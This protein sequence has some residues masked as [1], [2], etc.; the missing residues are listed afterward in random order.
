[1]QTNDIVKVSDLKGAHTVFVYDGA[2]N[3][4]FQDGKIVVTGE[5]ATKGD[6]ADTR[7][8]FKTSVPVAISNS[9]K[10]RES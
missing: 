6:A 3:F 9:R 8:P 10:R 1:M 7:T 2:E 4:L 5:L